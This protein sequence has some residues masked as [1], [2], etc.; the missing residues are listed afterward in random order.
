MDV[1]I[2]AKFQAWKQLLFLGSYFQWKSY[3]DRFYWY[4]LFFGVIA[5]LWRPFLMVPSPFRRHS[6]SMATVFIDPFS[7]LASR[8]LYGDH[9]FS[10]LLLFGVMN[11]LWRP[12]L[13]VPSLFRRLEL[14]MAT[15][16]N[17]A[18][19]FSAS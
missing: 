15:V 9:F 11:L 12:F 18:F 5:L 13:M 10:G 19:S 1:I 4:L 2:R 16:F 7:F 6:P 14:S 3:S 17:G 8:T